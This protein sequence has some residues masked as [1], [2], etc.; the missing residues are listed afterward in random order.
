MRSG[1]GGLPLVF[2]TCSGILHL[3]SQRRNFSEEP[4]ASAGAKPFMLEAGSVTSPAD[5]TA[6]AGLV[7]MGQAILAPNPNAYGVAATLTPLVA[8]RILA[9][10]DAAPRA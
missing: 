2:T 6:S 7:V 5:D 1:H 8:D 4:F 10:F 9:G 3:R